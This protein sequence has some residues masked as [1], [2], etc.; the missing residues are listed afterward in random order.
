[1]IVTLILM[2]FWRGHLTDHQKASSKSRKSINQNVHGGFEIM[3]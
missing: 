3:R 1:M 2:G